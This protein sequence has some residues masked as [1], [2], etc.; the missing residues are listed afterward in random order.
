LGE[1]SID[2]QISANCKFVAISIYN[3]TMFPLA[4][5][6]KLECPHCGRIGTAMVSDDGADGKVRID[7]LPLGFVVVQ[8][9]A[10]AARDDVRCSTCNSSA[11][12]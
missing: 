3:L 6:I 2:V 4:W 10:P 12:K 7:G 5:A 1:R 9:A 8:R 11:L